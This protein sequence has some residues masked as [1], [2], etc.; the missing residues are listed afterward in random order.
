MHAIQN[1]GFSAISSRPFYCWGFQVDYLYISK[2]M[3]FGAC[4]TSCWNDSNYPRLLDDISRLI[5]CL[6]GPIL[7]DHDVLPCYWYSVVTGI[8]PLLL[9]HWLKCIKRFY[10]FGE[11]L[12]WGFLEVLFY[13]VISSTP[14]LWNYFWWWVFDARSW[15]ELFFTRLVGWYLIFY[16][17]H[18][19]YLQ[20]TKNTY[21]VF[22]LTKKK[23]I[24]I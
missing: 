14:V 18:Y 16:P 15:A 12:T 3:I 19:T 23:D 17:H 2:T 10:R 7:R 9:I 21:Y 1:L 4:P 22:T 6:H 11:L 24:L 13:T 5:N 8:L 20:R